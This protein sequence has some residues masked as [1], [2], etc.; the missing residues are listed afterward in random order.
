MEIREKLRRFY[1]WEYFWL[2][3]IV[4]ATL[5]MHLVIITNP[6]DLILDEQH[7]INDA[8]N[9]IIDAETVRAE[10][11]PLAKLFFVAGEYIFSGF[12]SPQKNTGTTLQQPVD[13]DGT[14]IYVS[15]ASVFSVATT[16]RIGT[17]N[18]YIQSIDTSLDKL[19]VKRGFGTTPAGHDAQQTIY[20]FDDNPW[21]WRVF[22]ILFG[23]A[24]IVLFYFICRRLDMSPRASS[25]AAFLLALENLTF[26]QAS[27]AMLDVFYVT[28]MLAAFLLYLHRK[29]IAT[30]VA[31]GLSALAKL[32]GAM[33]GPVVGI[34]W[35]FTRGW[36]D[37]KWFL[38]TIFFAIAAFIYF[39]IIFDFTI[40]RSGDGFVDPITRIKTMLTQSGSL[41]YANVDHPSKSYPW[42][43]LYL[44][45]PMAYW[46]MPHYTAAISFTIW[47]LIVPSFGYM[48]FRA[49]KG[50]D[51]A[52]FGLAWFTG[53]YLLWM[54]AVLITDRVSYIFYFYPTVGAVCIG[55]GLGLERLL[56]LFQ[57]RRRGKLKWT[58]LSIVIIFLLAHLLSFIILSPLVPVDFA[59]LVGLTG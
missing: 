52:R 38:I 20:V 37:N 8:R 12:K 28:I 7:Y 41:T 2:C 57:D 17:E 15:D 1:R 19:T 50:S 45:K 48:V 11:P 39:M 21:G 23:T 3:I 13:S 31:V 51:A 14:E 10:H 4:L 27:V 32:S 59:K 22:P 30:G 18:M 58:A 9:I 35:L 44:Y 43:W 33:A 42:E 36:R 53:T 47:A 55:L 5:V 46:I 25:I 24:G 26:V 54:V 34:H 6:A 29:Y 16:I 49:I 40:V 56:Q